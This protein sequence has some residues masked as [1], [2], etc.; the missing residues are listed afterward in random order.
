MYTGRESLFDDLGK[1]A[2]RLSGKGLTVSRSHFSVGPVFKVSSYLTVK[3]CTVAHSLISGMDFSVL[4]LI[5]M[6]M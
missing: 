1:T 4:F 5:G 2:F 3:Y 6:Y